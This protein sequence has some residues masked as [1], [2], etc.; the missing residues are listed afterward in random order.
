MP[1]LLFL[2][3]RPNN[4]RRRQVNRRGPFLTQG[5][6][7]AMYLMYISPAQ[8]H[9]P[10]PQIYFT[11]FTASGMCYS[12][13]GAG[14]GTLTLN[15]PQNSIYHP[16]ASAVT[17][18]TY[19]GI[20][21]ASYLPPGFTALLNSTT[22]GQ[23]IVCDTLFEADIT[24]QSVAD[25]VAVAVTASGTSGSPSSVGAAI[26][27]PWTKTQTSSSGRV[28]REQDYP[29]KMR[30]STA[31]Y[32]GLPRYLYENDVSGNFVG[33]ATGNPP[34]T[35]WL[36]MNIN[37]GDNQNFVSALELRFRITYFVKVYSLNTET[38]SARAPI[39]EIKRPPK[40]RFSHLKSTDEEQ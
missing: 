37:T 28:Y 39:E 32:L 12:A 2:M 11:K 1:V 6:S 22:Y 21:P 24:P 10:L 26:G 34:V 31:D 33:G 5:L 20:T 30:I 17:G 25:S 9:S 16:F 13:F 35:Q 4:R 18:V 19:V 14:S 29:L 3:S 15:F 36:V 38:L 8:N 23:F 27:K 40:C 7:R